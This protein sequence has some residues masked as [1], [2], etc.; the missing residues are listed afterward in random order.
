MEQHTQF[1]E[2]GSGIRYS[3]YF[4]S[5]QQQFSPEIGREIYVL[6]WSEIGY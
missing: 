2:P 6:I 4:S 5:L 1:L 3:S